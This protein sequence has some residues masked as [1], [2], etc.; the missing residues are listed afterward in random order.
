MDKG[1]VFYGTNCWASSED[2]TKTGL[3]RVRSP[4]TF[5][6]LGKFLRS[7][8]QEGKNR[9]F[10]LVLIPILQKKSCFVINAFVLL[11]F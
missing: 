1:L 5:A 6:G 4:F 3:C 11:R 7:F 9:S 10:V 2:H 8:V